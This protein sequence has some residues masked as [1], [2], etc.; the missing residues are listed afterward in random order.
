MDYKKEYTVIKG[1]IMTILLVLFVVMSV[2]FKHSYDMADL[3]TL[4]YRGF[5]VVVI[6]IFFNGL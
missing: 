4:I 1:F 6:T 2:E 3:Q 5:W